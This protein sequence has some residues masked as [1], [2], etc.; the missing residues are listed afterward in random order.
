MARM[1]L[2]WLLVGLYFRLGLTDR[3]NH[4]SPQTGVNASSTVYLGGL[5]P[6]HGA[7]GL[8]NA[9]FEMA[10]GMVYAVET[11]NQNEEILPNISLGFD[12]HDTF[13]HV[14]TAL[15]ESLAFLSQQCSGTAIG[16]NSTERYFSGVVG[17]ASSSVSVPLASLLRL[18]N[19]PQISPASTAESLS[20]K[21]EFEFFYRTV[22]PDSGQVQ[23]MY[24]LVKL[25]NW[26][27]VS[28]IY[29]A[30]VYGES[31]FKGLQK[32]FEE[33]NSSNIC[34]AN[35]IPL[36]PTANDLAYDDAVNRLMDNYRKNATVV[37]LFAIH[38]TAIRVTQAWQRRQAVNPRDEITW[39]VS[40]SAARNLPWARG[41]LGVYPT[42]RASANSTHGLSRLV[43]TTLRAAHG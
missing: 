37:I 20:N 41:M 19:L 17:A 39:I 28:I 18:F 21:E 26:T 25:F 10:M 38:R 4:V 22:P 8:F 29:S 36:S 2:F 5:F 12:I 13:R 15:E 16:A 43:R 7:G 33:D 40:D 42:S 6:V 30:D 35:S 32:A 3:I 31:G 27:Y 1:T 24:N 23:V 14:N 34:I 9:G 11:I